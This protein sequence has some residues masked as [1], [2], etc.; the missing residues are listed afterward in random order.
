MERKSEISENEAEL[1]TE[2][3]GIFAAHLL[4]FALAYFYHCNRS[5]ILKKSVTHE[6]YQSKMFFPK[7]Y[8]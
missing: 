5:K 6:N 7:I 2:K 3:N 1:L 4:V 8:L